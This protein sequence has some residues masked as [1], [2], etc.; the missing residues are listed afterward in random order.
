MEPT[1]KSYRS[2]DEPTKIFKERPTL[3]E[4]REF[5]KLPWIRCISCGKPTAHLQEQFDAILAAKA[6]DYYASLEDNY[7]G[8]I[9]QGFDEGSAR[10]IADRNARIYADVKFNEKATKLGLTRY[11]CMR[12]LE[13]PIIN[14]LGSGISLDPEVDIGQRLSQIKIG[15]QKAVLPTMKGESS[16]KPVRIRTLRAI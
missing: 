10:Q 16:T 2:S 1:I 5:A 9:S 7:N 15:T 14:P 12:T 3:E 13:T 4:L 8:L 6:D 11:C